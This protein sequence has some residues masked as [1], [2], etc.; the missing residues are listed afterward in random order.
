MAYLTHLTMIKIPE[1]CWIFFSD[2]EVNMIFFGK[3]LVWML[4]C[5]PWL[6][7]VAYAQ[8]NPPEHFEWSML[9]WNVDQIP[10][11]G[12]F[13]ESKK[14]AKKTIEAL[15]K[16]DAD[17]IVLQAVYRKNV[18]KRFLKGLECVYPYRFAVTQKT[19]QYQKFTPGLVVASKY[20]IRMIDFVPFTNGIDQ[21]RAFSK[22]AL[23]FEVE[24]ASDKKIQVLSTHLQNGGLPHHQLVREKQLAIMKQILDKYRLTHIPQLIV[25]DLVIDTNDTIHYP[26]L[27]STLNVINEIGQG[28]LRFSVGAAENTRT[29]TQGAYPKLSDYLLLHNTSDAIVHIESKK[30]VRYTS[31]GR[32]NRLMD[33]SNHYGVFAQIHWN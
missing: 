20:P 1:F 12:T 19:F 5:W 16:S 31:R 10:V 22:G 28:D 29:C 11:L 4:F 6:G 17:L 9:S 21:D 30:L 2:I 25:G 26:K 15:L 18:Q 32:K 3:L 24:F 13:L 23:L 8:D 7:A 27:L 33:L 14:R